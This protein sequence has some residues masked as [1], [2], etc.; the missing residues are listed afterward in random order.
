MKNPMRMKNQQFI[1]NSH[2]NNNKEELKK[3]GL[4]KIWMK[5]SKM[6]KKMLPNKKLRKMMFK[7]MKMRVMKETELLLALAFLKRAMHRIM[8]IAITTVVMS[9]NE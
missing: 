6:M 1:T 2:R 4:L 3:N 7:N 5:S 8:R 9:S